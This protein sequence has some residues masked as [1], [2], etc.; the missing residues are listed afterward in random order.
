MSILDA[1]EAA[2]LCNFC[3]YKEA[4]GE[5]DDLCENEVYWIKCAV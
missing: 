2:E 1:L 4:S 5:R 3:A